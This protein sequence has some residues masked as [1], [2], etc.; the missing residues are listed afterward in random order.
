MKKVN[1]D[2]PIFIIGCCNSGTTSLLFALNSHPQVVAF[3]ENLVHEMG[4]TPRV[5]ELNSRLYVLGEQFD[6]YF[7][8][9]RCSNKK[10]IG[11]ND[12]FKTIDN[13]IKVC[14]EKNMAIN[15]E[16][17]L[18]KDPR[19]SLRVKWIKYVFPNAKI[20]CMVRSPFAVAEGIIRHSNAKKMPTNARLAANQYNVVYKII[21]KS[22][23]CVKYIKYED[24]IKNKTGREKFWQ[25]ILEYCGLQPNKLKLPCD[26]KWTKFNDCRNDWSLGQLNEQQADIIKHQTKDIINKFY[27]DTY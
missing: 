17:V 27:A 6:M 11:V 12:K 23:D 8:N 16:R 13:I 1:L 21:E 19:L 22:E 5:E 3:R 18:L 26:D 7:Q 2:S 20:L 14:L 24:M 15:G 4:I 9:E 25:E 10:A